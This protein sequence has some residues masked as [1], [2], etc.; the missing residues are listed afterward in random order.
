MYVGL[1]AGLGQADCP[2]PCDVPIRASSGNAGSAGSL[3]KVA[4][5]PKF[6]VMV[7]GAPRECYTEYLG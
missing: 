1:R 5:F 6:C 4:A 3:T 7:L 2:N